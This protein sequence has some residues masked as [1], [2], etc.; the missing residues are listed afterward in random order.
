MKIIA[1]GGRQHVV[2]APCHS[3]DCSVILNILEDTLTTL[4]A[5]AA[6]QQPTSPV[7]PQQAVISHIFQLSESRPLTW[8]PVGLIPV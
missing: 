7:Q 2:Y 3:S 8:L 6:M 4:E 5:V 1:Y